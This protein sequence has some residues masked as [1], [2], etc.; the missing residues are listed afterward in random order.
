MLSLVPT[1]IL[2]PFEAFPFFYHIKQTY[3]IV[4]LTTS[5]FMV[6]QPFSV[7]CNIV[8]LAFFGIIIEKKNNNIMGCITN[9]GVKA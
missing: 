7:K 5:E 4:S 3:T 1:F 9:K 6:F 8:H 2:F